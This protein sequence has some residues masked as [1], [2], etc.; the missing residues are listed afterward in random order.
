MDF[1]IIQELLDIL[2]MVLFTQQ[3]AIRKRLG[4]D[5]QDSQLQEGFDYVAKEYLSH[6]VSDIKDENTLELVVCCV[7]EGFRRHNVA[8][9]MLKFIF[10][11]ENYKNKTIQLTVLAENEAA[12]KLYS[13]NGFVY[14][15]EIIDGEEQIE[16]RKGFAAEG[17]ERPD[18][19]KMYR[20]A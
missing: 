5:F 14:K 4:P 16:I 13:Q 11:N 18:V 15:Y 20:K 12:R 7:D 19:C 9:E 6:V 8:S 1:Q 17:L 10:N 2:M 3:K